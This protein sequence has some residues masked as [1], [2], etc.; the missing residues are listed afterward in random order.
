[1]AWN[2]VLRT[3]LDPLICLQNR[4]SYLYIAAGY[5]DPRACDSSVAFT[6]SA[7]L[8]VAYILINRRIIPLVKDT[9]ELVSI[10]IGFLL[11]VF[12]SIAFYCFSF[13]ATGLR[14]FP[15]PLSR[16]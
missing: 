4:M 10:F 6:A 2:E 3:V 11:V 16:Q 7:V 13:K 5:L 15:Q 9:R 14:P 12:I 8:L 1:M